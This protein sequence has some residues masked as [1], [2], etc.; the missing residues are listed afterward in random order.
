MK[1]K[2]SSL[3]VFI[4]TIALIMSLFICC[5]KQS[6]ENNTADNKQGQ[7]SPNTNISSSVTTGTALVPETIPD[8]YLQDKFIEPKE[9]FTLDYTPYLPESEAAV[10]NK[11]KAQN[12][13]TV[14]VQAQ[15]FQ[16]VIPGLR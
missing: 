3:L 14:N 5:S 2:C 9:I 13:N 16:S 7:E 12:E 8:S 4:S 10:I 11:I 1:T 6:P 15:G